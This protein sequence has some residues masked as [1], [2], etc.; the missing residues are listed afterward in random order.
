M[1]IYIYRYVYLCH[2]Y[3]YM[4]THTNTCIYVYRCQNIYAYTNIHETQDR[5]ASECLET[6]TGG[7]LSDGSSCSTADDSGKPHTSNSEP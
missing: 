3:I 5:A 4:H 6:T 2:S 7:C 1:Y